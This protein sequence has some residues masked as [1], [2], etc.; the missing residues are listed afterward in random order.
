MLE[1]TAVHRLSPDCTAVACEPASAD[2]R[3]MTDEQHR[4]AAARLGRVWSTIGFEPSQDGVGT[5]ATLTCRAAG[6]S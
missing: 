5:S 4:Q 1:G 2:G 3:E 6:T